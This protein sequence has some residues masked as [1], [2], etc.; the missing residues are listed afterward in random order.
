MKNKEYNSFDKVYSDY[1]FLNR[2]YRNCICS[3]DLKEECNVCKKYY[4]KLDSCDEK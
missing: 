4:E 2:D 1:N 3:E